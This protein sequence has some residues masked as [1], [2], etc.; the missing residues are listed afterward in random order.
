MRI[1]PSLSKTW[2]AALHETTGVI[3]QVGVALFVLISAYFSVGRDFRVSIRLKKLW[4]QVFFYSVVC[5]V[6]YALLGGTGGVRGS[7]IHVLQLRET[8]SSLLPITF[9]VY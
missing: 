9:L 7:F 4:V 1:D 3:S 6:A 2:G 5:M 8:I